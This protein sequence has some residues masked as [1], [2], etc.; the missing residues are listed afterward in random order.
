M[1]KA[2]KAAMN[3]L[4]GRTTT[5]SSAHHRRGALR[6]PCNFFNH[7]HTL[8]ESHFR[9]SFMLAVVFSCLSTGCQLKAMLIKR[10]IVF[11]LNAGFEL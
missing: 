7:C 4:Q 8:L 9:S 5:Q 10:A 3:G 2:M 11:T 1:A 6:R